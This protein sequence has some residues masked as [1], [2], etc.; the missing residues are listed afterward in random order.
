MVAGESSLEIT[1]DE[2]SLGFEHKDGRVVLSLARG[3]FAV[4]IHHA[5]EIRY[6]I[7]DDE[8]S[9]IYPTAGS[10]AELCERFD[11]DNRRTG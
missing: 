9:L 6:A 1:D 11:V 7:C 4:K 2:A 8:M 3:L 5:G 10:L